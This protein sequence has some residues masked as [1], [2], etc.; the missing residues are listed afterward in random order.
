[1]NTGTIQDHSEDSFSYCL[2][3]GVAQF[4]AKLGGRSLIGRDCLE[5]R[6]HHRYA[7][8]VAEGMIGSQK[9]SAPV[10]PRNCAYHRIKRIGA[11]LHGGQRRRSSAYALSDHLGV[12]MQTHTP[13]LA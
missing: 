10:V 7:L 2:P 9:Q 1:M 13:H 8:L 6:L 4:F 5:S 11:K 12:S 3:V